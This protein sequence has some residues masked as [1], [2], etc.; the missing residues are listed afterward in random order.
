MRSAQIDIFEI[1]TNDENA[2]NVF[3][4]SVFCVSIQ[5]VPETLPI[6]IP[7]T[8]PKTIPIY[9]HRIL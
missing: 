7:T 1:D 2:N 5:I 6:P 9:G 4:E 8:V 3:T